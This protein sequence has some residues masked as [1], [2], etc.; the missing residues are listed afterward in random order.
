ML[1]K[2]CLPLELANTVLTGLSA[3]LGPGPPVG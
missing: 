3:V 1:D 2:Q